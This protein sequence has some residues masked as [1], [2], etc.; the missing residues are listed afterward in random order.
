MGTSSVGQYLGYIAR[1]CLKK[2]EGKEKE[3]EGEEGTEGEGKTWT[4]DRS[5]INSK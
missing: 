1:T 5:R 2:T 4:G 3:K